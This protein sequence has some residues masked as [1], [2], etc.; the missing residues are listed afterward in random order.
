MRAATC[1][2]STAWP[3]DMGVRRHA[4]TNCA[5]VVLDGL[6]EAI[7]AEVGRDPGRAATAR[8]LE[9]TGLP[10]PRPER[11]DT[12]HKVSEF[13]SNEVL[14]SKQAMLAEDVARDRYLRNRESLAELRAT[15]LICAPVL[16]E[17]QRARA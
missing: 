15:S 11:A 3:C 5:E 17:R 16:F 10:A 8:E 4:T 12:Y 1:R 9:V 14:S 2:C 13:V 7:P 6:L